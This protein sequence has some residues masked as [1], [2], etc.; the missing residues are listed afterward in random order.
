MA[1]KR[2]MKIAQTSGG[3][4][5]VNDIFSQSEISD[6]GQTFNDIISTII[7]V[8]TVI[9]GIYF[10]FVL[11]IGALTWIGAGDNKNQVEEA[12]KK[13]TTGL[14]GIT[15]TVAAVFIVQFIGTIFGFSDILDPG[16]VI[17]SLSF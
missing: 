11:I 12:K 4:I 13:I 3:S 5:E 10:F 15:V 17:E 8:M 9:A 16:G 2:F 7:G 1:L 14:I 6:A